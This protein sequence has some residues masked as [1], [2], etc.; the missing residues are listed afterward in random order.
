MAKRWSL[1]EY[2]MSK[3][4]F[5]VSQIYLYLLAADLM[6]ASTLFIVGGTVEWYVLPVSFCIAVF[7]LGLFYE[8]PV[9][10]KIIYEIVAAIG[11]LVIMTYL[12]GAVYDFSYDGNTY[13]KMAVGLLKNGWNPMKS[14]AAGFAAQNAIGIDA[15]GTEIWMESYCKESWIFGASIYS[16]TGNIECGKVYTMIAMVCAFGLTYAYLRHRMKSVR[17]SLIFSVVSMLN[18]IAIV[19]M[20]TFYVDGYLQIMLYILV[21]SLIM[22]VDTEYSIH[23]KTSASLTACAMVIC[24]NVKFTGLLYGGIFCIAYYL[25]QC[26]ADAKADK[27]VF[28]KKCIKKGMLFACLAA[29]TMFWAGSSVYLLNFL[30]HGTF[31]YPLTGKNAIDIISGNSPFAE[32]NHFKNLFMSL[33]SKMSDFTIDTNRQPELK[34]PFSIYWDEESGILSYADAR[35]SGFGILFSG[36]LVMALVGIVMWLFHTAREK[37]FYFWM[38]N[39]AV[40]MGICLLLKESW[41][42]RYTPCIYFLSLMGFYLIWEM[43]GKKLIRMTAHIMAIVFLMNSMLFFLPLLGVLKNS[44]DVRDRMRSL[45][46]HRLVYLDYSDFPGACF[47][48]MDQGVFMK[49][50]SMAAD[51][52]AFIELGYMGMKYMPEQ[53]TEQ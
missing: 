32:E 33:F 45:A 10:I 14:G 2:R 41:W 5:H 48:V 34:I 4:L 23:R 47:N 17:F 25:W 24:G 11:L 27:S 29:V 35:I 6:V 3:M 21:L 19:Q 8:D 38:M 13:H 15:T 1:G 31:T 26:A 50:D 7:M 16:L 9:D 49:I 28:I 37:I 40:N 53:G 36:V 42:A 44:R 30:H 39:L 18:P 22:G 52:D 43:K 51:N 12:A 20:K 46:Q